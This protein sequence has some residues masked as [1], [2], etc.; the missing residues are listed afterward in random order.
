MFELFGDSSNELSKLSPPLSKKW[1]CSRKQSAP[2]KNEGALAFEPLRPLQLSRE[3]FS[4][5][6]QADFRLALRAGTKIG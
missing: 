4:L 3:M 6:A 5:S 1:L 2:K